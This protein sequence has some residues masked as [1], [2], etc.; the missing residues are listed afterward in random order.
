MHRL[1]AS[2][3]TFVLDASP[4]LLRLAYRLTGDRQLAEDLL[5]SALLRV[6]R[7]WS[8]ARERPLAYAQRAVVNLATDGWRRRRVR[9]RRGAHGR[10]SREPVRR[11]RRLR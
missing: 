1:D 10:P 6:A 2:F 8:R 5:Q 3:D 11:G 4:Q 7:N 9:P